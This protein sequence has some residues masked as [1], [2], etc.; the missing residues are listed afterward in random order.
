MIP[1]IANR[2]F[3]Y[4]VLQLRRLSGLLRPTKSVGLAMTR[5]AAVTGLAM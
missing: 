3:F 1:I 5:V 4:A 2:V